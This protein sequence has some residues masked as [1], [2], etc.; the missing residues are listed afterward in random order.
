MT[1]HCLTVTVALFVAGLAPAAAQQ[2]LPPPALPPPPAQQPAAAPPQSPSPANS[3]PPQ[4]APPAPSPAQSPPLP[5]GQKPLTFRTSTRLVVQTVTIKDKD[6]KIV[7]GLTPDDLAVTED[8]IAQDIAFVELEHIGTGATLKPMPAPK[9]PAGSNAATQVPI[10]T[11]GP[12]DARYQNRRLL[13][14]YFDLAAMPMPDRLRAFTNAQKFLDGQMAREDAVAVVT[15]QGGGVRVKQDFTDNRARLQDVIQRLMDGGDDDGDGIPDASEVATAFGQDDAEF[16]IFNT[17]RQLAALQTAVTLLQSLPEQKALI[18]FGSGMRLNG[19]DNQAQLRATINAAIKSNVTIHPIDARGL[20]ARAPLGDATRAS[21]GGIDMFSG[22]LAENVTSAFQRSQDTLYALAKDTGGKAMF[23]YNDLSLGIADAA[24]SI[25]SYYIVGYYSKNTAADGKFH[26]VRIK[27]AGG[28]TGELAYRQG[29]YSDR[30]FGTFSAV[31]KERQLEEALLLENPVTDIQMAMEVNYFQ[32]NPAE[33]FVP[34]AIKIPG[35]ELALARKRNA[36]RTTIDFI[37]EVKDEY[38]I[39]VQNVRDKL[40]I[41]LS[42]DMAAQ[43]ANRPVQYE[44]GFTLLPGRYLIKI[45]A[46]D[47]ETGRIG[48]FQAPFVIPNLNHEE[49]RLPISSVVLSSQRVRMADALYNVKGSTPVAHPLVADGQKLVPHV[50]RVFSRSRDLY[51]FLQAYQ[52]TATTTQPVVA[53]ATFFAGEQKVFESPLFTVT[54][55]L[56][57]RSKAVPIGFSV[58][59]ASLN[60]GRYDCQVTV[61]E[62]DVAK[63][64]F[65]RTPLVVVP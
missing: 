48:T 35:R 54:A 28:R 63:V 27:L 9:A 10:A 1:R 32:L 52:R 61:L 53:F 29:Y 25:S 65:W 62:P 14:F 11:P 41:A 8:G 24:H 56:Q 20:V 36:A 26:R 42:G 15:F 23:D 38:G 55:G 5:D 45:L 31:E 17:D 13:V 59:L 2:L 16:N 30:A 50:T 33:Y 49:L 58:P 57:D 19:T 12:G 37:G 39:T 22:K 60:P 34:V 51:V 21:P 4:S 7:E 3:S 40:N 47:A 6:G 43:L 18:Y 46:R 64:A 44:T